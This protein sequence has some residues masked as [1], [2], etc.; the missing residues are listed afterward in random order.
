MPTPPIP[1]PARCSSR[2]AGS[3]SAELDHHA[4]RGMQNFFVYPRVLG[5]QLAVEVLAVGAGETRLRPGDLCAVLPYAS[6]GTCHRPPARPGQLLRSH[7]RDGCHPGRRSA[8]AHGRSCL[9]PLH[10]SRPHP[11]PARPRRDARGRLARGRPG[12]SRSPTT[13]CWCSEQARSAWLSWKL[14]VPRWTS[15]SSPTS[16]PSGLRSPTHPA[17]TRSSSTESS[18]NDC[19]TT[20][21]VR[22]RPWCSTRTGSRA[23]MGE[24]VRTDRILRHPRFRGPHDGI[25]P[26]REPFVPC[27]R[28]R[29]PCIVEREPSLTGPR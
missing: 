22:C 29:P 1:D 13:A 2:C 10:R 5:H 26:I 4:Y 25:D 6:C 17:T 7:R 12:L 11:G 27:P 19:W 20:T 15:W 3:G 28:A 14:H 18:R 8:G 23:S 9:P 24:R 16:R 21:V